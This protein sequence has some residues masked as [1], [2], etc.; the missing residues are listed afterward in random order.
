MNYNPEIHHRRSIRLKGYDYSKAGVYFITLCTKNRLCLFGEIAK[1]KMVL[2][3]HGTIANS[4]L[5]EIPK[6]YPNVVLREHIIMPN[7]V[8]AII[9]IT[10][11]PVETIHESSNISQ[12]VQSVG[13][14][15][16]SSLQTTNNTNNRTIR[17]SSE[18]LPLRDQRRKMLLSKIVGRYKMKT[19]KEINIIRHIEGVPL[20]QSRF[21]DHIIRNEKSYQTIADYIINNPKNWKEDK[22]YIA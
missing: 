17:E 18:P 12:Q 11:S 10:H 3:E 15:H 16:E 14:I 22:F 9:I 13:M 20:W 2:N 19:A 1:G 6:Q 5:S 4:Y 8:H 21:H 7:H